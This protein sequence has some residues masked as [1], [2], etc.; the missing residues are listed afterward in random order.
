MSV[1]S[2][3]SCHNTKVYL[4]LSS[5]H[6]SNTPLQHGRRR[7]ELIL[8]IEEWRKSKDKCLSI[9]GNNIVLIL[10]LIQLLPIALPVAQ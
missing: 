8:K 9:E 10:Q 4:V 6:S 1:H 3:L 7:I 5:A 2:K